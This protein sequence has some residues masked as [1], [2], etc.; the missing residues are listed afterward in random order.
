MASVGPGGGMLWTSYWIF[1]FHKRLGICLFPEWLLTSQE[2]MCAIQLA[3]HFAWN[4][5][6][7]QDLSQSFSSHPERQKKWER[8]RYVYGSNMGQ[9]TAVLTS[10]GSS[11][12]LPKKKSEPSLY[13]L[14]LPTNFTLW[15]ILLRWYDVI[16][17]LMN[18]QIKQPRLRNVV[19]CAEQSLCTAFVIYE[20]PWGFTFRWPPKRLVAF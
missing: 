7:I 2:W 13:R 18:Q 12:N 1:L 4:L 8:C 6:M 9:V 3:C 10:L 19:L 5:T 11:R 14:V 20:P 15:E 16:K 17:R